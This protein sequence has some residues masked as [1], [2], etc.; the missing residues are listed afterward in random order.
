MTVTRGHCLCRAVTFQYEGPER[1]RGYCHCDSCRRQ[2]SAP[3]TAFVGV[4][5]RAARLAGATLAVFESSPGVRR[6]FC[7]RCGS[8]VAYESVR[9]PDEI[10]FYTAALEHPEAAAPQ[11][12]ANWHE[13]LPWLAL[14]DALP[15]K[16]E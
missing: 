9:W 4:P 16:A 15:R 10:H 12:H 11:H 3:V 1:W 14:S 7:S 8:P 6:S 2:T 13:R 5:R